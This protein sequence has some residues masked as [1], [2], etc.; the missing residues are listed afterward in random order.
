M[1]IKRLRQLGSV[2]VISD[3]VETDLP[4]HAFTDAL[5]VRFEGSKITKIGGWRITNKSM[6]LADQ[7]PQALKSTSFKSGQY[8]VATNKCIYSLQPNDGYDPTNPNSLPENRTNVTPVDATAAGVAFPAYDTPPTTGAKMKLYDVPTNKRWHSTVVADRIVFNNAN[9]SPIAQPNSGVFT[10]SFVKLPGWGIPQN[11]GT[12]KGKEITWR[13]ERLH[14]FKDFLMA[15]NMSESES[16]TAGAALVNIANRVRWSDIAQENQL[17]ANWFDDDP[18]TSGGFVDLMDATSAIVDGSPLR[19]YF[20]VY[21]GTETYLFQ[22]VGGN[23]VF[24]NQKLFSDSG[25]LTRGC[26]AEFDGQ[27]VVVTRDDVIIHDGSQKQSIIQGTLRD[28]FIKEINSVNSDAVRVFANPVRKEV[29][30]CYPYSAGNLKN[31]L[32]YRM[33]RAAIY[34]FINKTWSFT[35]LPQ[36]YSLGFV[37]YTDSDYLANWEAGSNAYPTGK[38]WETNPEPWDLASLQIG[39]KAMIG[40]SAQ[41]C[42]M[43]MDNGDYKNTITFT[44]GNTFTNAQEPLNRFV[45][46]LWID[47]DEDA[48]YPRIKTLRRAFPQVNGGGEYDFTFSCSDLQTGTIYAD[49]AQAFTV[50]HDYKVDTFNTARFHHYRVDTTGP[51]EWG[52]SGLDFDYVVEGLR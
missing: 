22:Y 38:D 28:R 33:N 17:P 20:M 37:E 44:S 49:P 19:D 50:G 29:W 10:A 7:T 34:S 26:V 30:V 12:N 25:I 5:N 47:F 8:F 36:I 21:T 23:D 42:L 43:V 11:V 27:H 13:C 24:T 4:P 51:A 1:A 52:F 40:C 32:E 18:N 31:A 46:R 15:L 39:T 48:D 9:Y 3:M 2:G 35:E 14:A 41:H 45:E 16:F 6:A